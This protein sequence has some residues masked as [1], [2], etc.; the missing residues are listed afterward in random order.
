[1]SN[2]S[3]ILSLFVEAG[4]YIYIYIDQDV[5]CKT[6]SPR[7]KLKDREYTI[8]F[9]LFLRANGINYYGKVHMLFIAMS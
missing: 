4:L 2:K 9:T 5:I 7:I 6:G 8:H 3:G 1:M